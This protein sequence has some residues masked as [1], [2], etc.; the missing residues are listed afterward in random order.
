MGKDLAES[1]QPATIPRVIVRG[2]RVS[3]GGSGK[4]TTVHAPHPTWSEALDF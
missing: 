1:C 4:S 2:A 3:E